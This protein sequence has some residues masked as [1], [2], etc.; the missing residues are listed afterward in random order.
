M[1]GSGRQGLVCLQRKWKIP[2]NR[3]WKEGNVWLLERKGHLDGCALYDIWLP[4]SVL[5]FLHK[6][7][8]ILCWLSCCHLRASFAPFQIFPSVWSFVQVGAV[9]LPGI[10]SSPSFILHGKFLKQATV[11]TLLLCCCTGS[12]E[13]GA[14]ALKAARLT[15]ENVGKWRHLLHLLPS[16]QLLMHAALRRTFSCESMHV[17]CFSLCAF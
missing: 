11:S 14:S 6:M 3:K 12:S 7:H 4:T 9:V 8:S 2:S 5:L 15:V 17:D 10:F 1:Y 13:T 16:V